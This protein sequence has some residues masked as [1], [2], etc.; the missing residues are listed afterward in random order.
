MHDLTCD[1]HNALLHLRSV[2]LIEGA[3]LLFLVG[4]AVPLKHLMGFPA[5]VSVAGP[6]HGLVF[7]FYL[8]MVVATA[9][10]ERWSKHDIALA[11]ALAM[12]PF[13]AFFN[14][15]ILLRKKTAA[16]VFHPHTGGVR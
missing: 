16:A 3:S 2:A 11:V 13:G 5:V 8:W 6:L 15:S 12:L 14:A 4:I 9:V 7:M 10:S 1:K